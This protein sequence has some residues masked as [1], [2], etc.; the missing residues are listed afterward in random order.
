MKLARLIVA[1]TNDSLETY[2]FLPIFD[3]PHYQ[4]H[5]ILC[6][7][8]NFLTPGSSWCRY[9]SIM[10][11]TRSSLPDADLSTRLQYLVAGWRGAERGQPLSDLHAECGAAA[12]PGGRHALP[13]ALVLVEGLDATTLRAAMVRTHG[14]R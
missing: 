9:R 6:P 4:H 14:L 10:Q 1:Y 12:G 7:T 2:S 8:Q 5:A 13:T 3:S 11:P